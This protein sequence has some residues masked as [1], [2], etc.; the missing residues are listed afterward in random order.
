MTSDLNVPVI[1]PM[2]MR[3]LRF[4]SKALFVISIVVFLVSTNVRWASSTLVSYNFLFDVTKVESSSKIPKDQLL[5][6]AQQIIDY[7][8]TKTKP[9]TVI[10]EVEGIDQ[11]VYS[12]R[13]ILHMKDVKDLF[14]KTYRIQEFSGGYLLLFS[15][16]L[17]YWRK[18]K[19]LHTI[20]SLSGIGASLAISSILL[21][22]LSSLL[23]SFQEVFNVFHYISFDNDLWIL[24][25]DTYLVRMYPYNFW[26]NATF[27]IGISTLVQGILLICV[28]RFRSRRPH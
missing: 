22:G 2:L 27:F 5:R 18:K 6:G 21:I 25:P 7:V 12:E 24:S 15:L 4:S 11:Q 13:E 19:A 20:A 28:S 3:L 8:H 14:Q 17:F 26:L 9:L 10:I 1:Q 23:L 16:A